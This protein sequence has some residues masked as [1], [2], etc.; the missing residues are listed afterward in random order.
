ME[1]VLVTG[2]T[3]SF[4]RAILTRLLCQ[5][6]VSEVRVLSRDEQKHVQLLREV[7]DARLVS[8]VGDVRDY[9]ACVSAAVGCDTVFHAAAI[10]HVPVAERQ[11]W[12]AVQTNIFGVHNMLRAADS[13]GVT[14]FVA[15][16]T[17]KAVAPINAMGMTKAVQEKLVHAFLPRSGMISCCVRYGNVLASRGSVIPYFKSILQSGGRTL[18]VT[19]PHMTRFMLTLPQAIDLVMYAAATGVAGDLFVSHIP[20]FLLSDLAAVML[21]HYGS[22]GATTVVGIRPGEKLHETLLSEDEM[23]CAVRV[24]GHYRINEA[25]RRDAD[26]G[27]APLTSDTCERLTREGIRDLLVCEGVL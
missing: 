15:V 11:P 19:S 17:D 27:V 16:S 6:S 20:A 14:R 13:A 25:L 5:P 12:E 8:V 26:A 22:E 3:G 2:G 7:G 23:R 21:A 18:P 4:G 24:G 9:T 1:R 10:K